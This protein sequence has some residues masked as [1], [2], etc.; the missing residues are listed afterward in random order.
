MEGVFFKKCGRA[1][2]GALRRFRF[3]FGGDFCSFW[4]RNF[5]GAVIVE[6]A[7]WEGGNATIFYRVRLGGCFLRFAF[8]VI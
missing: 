6:E 1:G 2:C 5:R 7:R 4:V 3:R 8:G